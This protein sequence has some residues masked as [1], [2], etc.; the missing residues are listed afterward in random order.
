MIY[1]PV[2]IATGLLMILV[3]HFALPLGYFEAAYGAMVAPTECFLGY[4]PE[5]YLG[6]ALAAVGLVSFKY[7]KAKHAAILIA[8]LT[9]VHAFTLEAASYYRFSNDAFAGWETIS[10]RQHAWISPVLAGFAIAIA[11]SAAVDMIARGRAEKSGLTRL[12]ISLA[13]IRQKAFRTVSLVLCITLV[14]GVF[15]SYLVLDYGIGSSISTAARR[16]GA[17]IVVVPEGRRQAAESVLLSGGP[18]MFYLH[19]DIL[20]GLRKLPE[21]E[22]AS[23]QVFLEPHPELVCCTIENIL[24]VAFDPANDF[25]VNPWIQYYLKKNLTDDEMI[26]GNLVKKYPGQTLKIY[27][28]RFNIIANLDTTGI[29]FFDYSA[30]I[31]LKAARKLVREIQ[32]TDVET[33]IRRRQAIGD[34][35]ISHMIASQ[36]KKVMPIQ[37]IPPDGV[38]AVFIKAANGV[39]VSKLSKKIEDA[40]KGVSVINIKQSTLS[41]KKDLTSAVRVFLFPVGIILSMATAI[42]AVIFGMS[43]NERRREIGLLRAMGATGSDVFRVIVYE[44]LAITAVGGIFG[45]ISAGALVFYFR[46]RIMAELGLLYIWPSPAAVFFILGSTII[47]SLAIGAGAALYP[48]LRA[49][50]MEPYMAIRSGE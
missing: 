8:V 46:N 13:G 25:T 37:K 4:H 11:V 7:E 17:D 42:L 27:G 36:D 43:V 44:A 40:F 16:L 20:P 5:A 50:R 22:R 38:S 9:A 23:P 39:S 33:E 34:L 18:A 31:T 45:M 1:S 47:V 41:V 29:G 12:K 32:Q 21:V 2:L 3:P 15:F 24:V 49:S 26:I 6:A 10:L 48:A 35:E 19:E 14:V 30:F 28:K